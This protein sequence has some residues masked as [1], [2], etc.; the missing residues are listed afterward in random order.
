MLSLHVLPQYPLSLNVLREQPCDG[1]KCGLGR[2]VGGGW[3]IC[4]H[5]NLQALYPILC[6]EWDYEKNNLNPS[7]FLSGS[8]KKV[9]WK[10]G[11][12]PCECHSWQTKICHRAKSGSECPFC[13]RGNRCPHNNLATT[14]VELCKEWDYERNISPPQNYTKGSNEKVWWKCSDKNKCDCHRWEATINHRAVEKTQCPFCVKGR[15]CEHYNFKVLFPEISEDWDY[16]RNTTNPE[17]YSPYSHEEIWWICSTSNCNCHRWKA[18]IAHRTGEGNNCPFCFLGKPCPHYNLLVASP[19]IASEW[20]YERNITKPEDYSPYA[21]IRV[22][23]KCKKNSSH[24]WYVQ[25]SSRNR[26]GETR[27]CPFCVNKAYSKLQI[28]WLNTIMKHEDKNILHAENEGEYHIQGVGS[29]D[30]FHVETNTVYEFHGDFY[31]GHPSKY[32]SDDINPFIGKSYGELYAKTLNRD[33]LIV[34]LGYNLVS[35]WEHEYLSTRN[36]Q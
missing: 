20:N 8:N 11:N 16:E 15:P 35:M 17:N 36:S 26:K 9:W 13:K 29:V 2:H 10:C 24:E 7:D 5:N 3:W 33:K 1:K 30:G 34:K 18:T 12:N 25:I 22:W 21:N 23:W 19:E 27:G 14:H 31:H 4:L 6:K 28:E 32:K